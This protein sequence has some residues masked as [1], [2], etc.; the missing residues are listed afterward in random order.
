[1]LMY[2]VVFATTKMTGV[3]VSVITFSMI[4]G[5]Y[6]SE[7]FRSAIQSVPR[8]QTEAGIALGFS[9]ISTFI[10]IVLPQAIRQVY[11]IYKGE[12][13]ALTKL[14]S[15]V[16]YIAVQDLTKASDLIRSRTFDAFFPLIVISVIYFFI[17]W[18]LARLLDAA[19]P[20]S[21]RHS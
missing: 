17:S 21:I 18:G 14:T 20:T 3:T 6:V 4:F 5:A 15:I 11:P 8:G 7:M 12:L 13:I 1:M 2:Y 10:H 9:K 16:G 19:L